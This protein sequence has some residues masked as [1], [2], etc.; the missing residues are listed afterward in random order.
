MLPGIAIFAYNRPYHL[1]KTLDSLEKNEFA[2]ELDLFFFCDGPKSKEDIINNKEIVKIY[3]NL[4][5]FKKKKIFRSTINKGLFKSMK[6]G[7]NKVFEEKDYV[8]VIEDDLIFNK[9]F[10]KYMINSL[11][12][13][14]NN[15]LVG[16]VSGYSFVDTELNE[17]SDQLYLSQR[18]SSWG[19][20]TWKHV[21]QKMIWQKHEIEQNINNSHFQ[22]KFNLLGNDMYYML[23]EN[24]NGNLDTLDILFNYNC[25]MLN[26]FC[27]CPKK[28]F[29]KN[30]GLDGSGIHC[31]KD[32][33]VFD[34]FSENYD[35]DKFP[36]LRLD[37]SI[38][39]KIYKKH[40]TNIIEK[41]QNSFRTPIIPRI[42]NKIKKILF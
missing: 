40:S 4:T 33:N 31:K 27:I 37:E 2:S 26:K 18:H 29:I 22:K 1:K 13:Y 30:I 34:N 14:K 3:N 38:L 17:A 23:R 42:T 24:L 16:S 6:D 39:K 21:W 10:L 25:N 28:S 19:W 35:I 8:I 7:I 15:N 32:E 20:G 12:Y 36:D 5:K 11:Q 41:I 9:F